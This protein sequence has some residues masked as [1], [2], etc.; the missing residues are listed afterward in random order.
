MYMHEN[1]YSVENIDYAKSLYDSQ[2]E[3]VKKEEY[4]REVLKNNYVMLVKARKSRYDLI[5]DAFHKAHEQRDKKLKKE[6]QDREM[7]TSFILDDFL[8]NDCNFKLKEIISCGWEHY[9][10]SLE[11]E[12]YDRTFRITI[13]IKNNITVDNIHYAYDGMFAFSVKTSSATWTV[14]KKS[15]RIDDIAEYIREYFKLSGP[16]KPYADVIKNMEEY[17]NE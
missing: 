4:I 12:G 6:R 9:A 11:F 3:K 8:N 7:L 1:N 16:E 14:M 13:P 10:W 15:H 2:V 5:S 17:A